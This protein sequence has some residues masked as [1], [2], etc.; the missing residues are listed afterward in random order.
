MSLPPRLR[1]AQVICRPLPPIV[2]QRLRSFIYP[3][4]LGRKDNLEVTVRSQ[5]GSTFTGRTRD[6]HA[7]PFTVHGYSE[8]RNTAIAVALTKP[9]DTIVE[10]GANVGT[11]TVGFSDIV[12]PRG[13]VFAFEPLPSNIAALERVM[14]MLQYKNVTLRPVGLSDRAG[15]VTFV[16]PRE[17]ESG[18]GH[19]LQEKE[20]VSTGTVTIDIATLDSYT[21][22]IGRASV[23]FMDTEGEELRILNGGRSFITRLKPVIVLEASAHHLGRA[24]FTLDDLKKVLDEL[25]Y[26]AYDIKRVS[27]GPIGPDDRGSSG[28]WICVPRE[29]TALI[30]RVNSYLRRSAFM[31][32]IGSLNPLRVPK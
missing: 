23:I 9:G 17:H 3:F 19:V 24:G 7:Y 27:I 32:F 1:L 13:Q 26:V 22:A 4:M 15:S 28:N 25:G 31:P 2:A 30:A 14:G 8:W 16:V 18:M 5:S 6:F 12:G 20:V 11:E 29:S 10:I 21:D